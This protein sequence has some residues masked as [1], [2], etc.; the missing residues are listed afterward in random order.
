MTN[1]VGVLLQ[2][3]IFRTEESDFVCITNAECIVSA[4]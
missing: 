4:Y 3:H 2:D 1:L